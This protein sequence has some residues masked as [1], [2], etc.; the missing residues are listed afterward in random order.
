M[1][2]GAIRGPRP[3]ADG[4]HIASWRVGAESAHNSS[5]FSYIALFGTINIQI[6]NCVASFCGGGGDCNCGEAIATVAIFTAAMATTTAVAATA[7]TATATAAT[8]SRLE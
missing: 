7:A 8:A 2:F 6:L 1:L 5:S 3:S 4:P